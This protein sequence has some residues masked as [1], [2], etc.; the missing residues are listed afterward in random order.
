MY[1]IANDNEEIGN[2]CLC[3][4]NNN[5]P[6]PKPE[7]FDDDAS[8]DG[9]VQCGGEQKPNKLQNAMQRPTSRQQSP[10]AKVGLSGKESITINPSR[11]SKS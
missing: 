7:N 11:C 5:K 4:T 8:A 1:I 6:K 3:S 10:A 2:L 9:A